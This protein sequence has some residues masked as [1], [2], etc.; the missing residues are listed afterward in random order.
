MAT[1]R[2]V[3]FPLFCLVLS[4]TQVCHAELP[5]SYELM[6]GT[7]KQE[8]LWEEIE[9]SAYH[10][11]RLP[12]ADPGLLSVGK[13]FFCSYLWASF[14]HASDEMPVGR[15]KLI[16]TYGSVAQVE[17]K[18]NSENSRYSGIFKS[19]GVGL[20]RLSLA[21]QSG[22]FTPGMALKIF[23][24]G[25]PSVNF[26]VMYSL[27][28][29]G[30]D[31]NFFENKFSNVITL[32]TGFAL[33]LLGGVFESAVKSLSSDPAERPESATHLPLLEAAQINADGIF[34]ATDS[35]VEP[36]QMIFTPNQEVK[37]L[38]SSELDQDMR[39][40]LARIPHESV[41]YS[42]SL[43]ATAHAEEEVI[44]QLV[45]KSS[46]VASEYGDTQLFFQHQSSRIIQK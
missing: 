46:F 28:G 26:Q 44:G 5:S 42:V 6:K 34:M 36:Y 32:P 3:H 35:I 27:E 30:D 16:H 38:L 9:K 29:Q 41:L 13:L 25:E 37:Q 39:L 22:S 31:R 1:L 8:V 21:K 14:T 7:Q 43:K 17:L 45:L 4:I 2:F 40:G 12:T 23:V 24:N 20:A 33:R 18:I 19:G 15:A 10:E 11:S